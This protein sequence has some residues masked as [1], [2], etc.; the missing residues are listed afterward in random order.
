MAEIPP[1][2]PAPD[3]PR[4]EPRGGALVAGKILVVDD[5]KNM[6]ATTAI[7]LR[8]GGHTVEEAEDGAAAV[9]RIQ[10]ET[11]DVVLTD[12]RMPSVD[13]MEVL[14]AAQRLAPETQV[15]VMTAYGTIE[16]AVDAIRQGAY[17]FLAKPFKEDE[18]LLRV[19]KALEK[20]R[21]L[22][23]VS[24]LAGEFRKRYGL[25]HIV[26]RSSAMRDVLDRVVRIA[27]TD[28]TV[29]VSGESGTGKELVARAIHVASRRG[30]KPFVP[31]NCAAITET[32][33]E[34]EL[35]GH[36]KGAFT[37]AVR[38]RRGMF[39]EA[40]GGTLFID[41][42]GETAPGFQAKLLR[43]L[44][45]GEIRRVGE[46]TPVQVDVRV[47]AATNQDLR[48]A[49]AERRFREDL[50]YRLAV[51]PVRIPPLRERREDVPLLAAHFLQ[52]YNR[53]TAEGKTLAPEALARLV[54]HDWPGNVRELENAIEQAAALSPGREIREGDVQLE[55]ARGL[56]AAPAEEART[57]AEAVEEA[58]RCAI[59]A[60]LAR[61]EGDLGRVA[62]E[63]GVSATTLWRKMKRLAIE[64][65]GAPTQ[66]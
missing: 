56:P 27:P 45:E 25:E 43:A 17:D 49:I 31:V 54:E 29:L 32:L 6:R 18:L 24:L 52:R 66:P 4:L 64:A 53:R 44:Q 61:C 63:L 37:G 11:F 47:I 50:Y 33:L 13:G 2:M 7:V 60:A 20:R 30:D 57:L 62:R 14:R 8:Q 12:L 10:Q 40:N 3:E 41:E 23:E 21:L 35:F 22:G 58:E 28:A 42:I 55:H 36:A 46:S 9:Q 15:I 59:E 38:A 16:S 5:Q 26:G 1:G 65:R 39:E 51:V 19:S 48:R 34:S